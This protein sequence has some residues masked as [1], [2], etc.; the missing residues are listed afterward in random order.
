[1]QAFL[2]FPE[3]VPGAQCTAP[4]PRTYLLRNYH[5][6]RRFSVPLRDPYPGL[7]HLN[8]PAFPVVI[9]APKRLRQATIRQARRHQPVSGDL[10]GCGAL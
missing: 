3:Y 5:N 9:V 6:A 8:R 7:I 2:Y 10:P 1:M 4:R